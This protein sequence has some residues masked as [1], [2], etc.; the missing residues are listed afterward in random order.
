MKLGA[1]IGPLSPS[2]EVGALVT[3]ARQLEDE[4]FDSLWTVQA[5]GRGL[6]IPDPLVSLAAAAAATRRVR[7]GTA[8]LQVPLY[9]PGELAHRI[10]SLMHLCGDRLQLGVGA[11]STEKD[12]E[13]FGRDYATRF[14]RFEANLSELRGLLATGAGDGI[15]LNPWPGVLGGPPLLLGTWGKGVARAA[16]EFSGWI[17]SAM[18]RTPEQVRE[19][20][21]TYRSNGGDN[22]IVS[23]IL[24]GPEREPGSNR[25][26]LD[27][28]AE[29][30][31][32]EAV[33]MLLPGGPA[34]GE[35]RSW[36]GAVDFA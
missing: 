32:D 14:A 24:L 10:F 25:K 27:V 20:L 19:A 35:V 11:G 18:N 17:A 16:K 36:V 13:V 15:D 4:G 7:L 23:S 34:A 12:F 30:G 5:V 26:R 22:A 33:V 31:F 21:A 6:M 2:P 28:F 3:Q 1:I 8:I 9:H 29:A